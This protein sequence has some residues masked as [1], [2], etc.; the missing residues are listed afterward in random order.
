VLGVSARDA[1][2]SGNP[3]AGTGASV[4][5]VVSGGAAEKAGVRTGD[6]ITALDDRIV[7]SSVDLTAAVRSTPPGKTVTLTVERGG[8]SRT[9]QV[10]LGETNG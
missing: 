7:T 5:Q 9:V 2:S 1:G 4:A 6:V 3:D 8:S 10:T